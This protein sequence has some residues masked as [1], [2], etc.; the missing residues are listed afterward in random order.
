MSNINA[1]AFLEGYMQKV[2]EQPQYA[3]TTPLTPEQMTQLGDKGQ[4]AYNTAMEKDKFNQFLT[5]KNVQD[6]GTT[7]GGA[8]LGGALGGIMGG[9]LTSTLMG[10]A[11][12]GVV[13]WL[14]KYFFPG[15]IQK[16]YQYA[17]DK[18]AE[19]T[20]G[21][22]IKQLAKTNPDAATKAP[23]DS[24]IKKVTTEV[25]GKKDAQ[26]LEQSTGTEKGADAVDV[27]DAANRQLKAQTQAVETVPAPKVGYQPS[28]EVKNIS[29]GQGQG[30]GQNYGTPAATPV[31]EEGMNILG[32]PGKPQAS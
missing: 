1:Q 30:P 21:Q 8:A 4:A 2:A 16:A 15:E 32:E 27:A 19:G 12:G 13:G 25:Q 10:T 22:T 18:N 5:N 6:Y 9:D 26:T 31:E 7:A 14:A 11:L 20:L 3:T 17:I 28:E 23:D 29:L 24:A